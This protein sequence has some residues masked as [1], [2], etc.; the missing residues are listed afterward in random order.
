MIRNLPTS[1]VLTFPL[2]SCQKICFAD[3]IYNRGREFIKALHTG[4]DRRIHLLPK[5]RE[6]LCS[7]Y[8]SLQPKALSMH[9]SQ[10]TGWAGGWC[11]LFPVPTQ[12]IGHFKNLWL[13]F[14][15]SSFPTHVLHDSREYTFKNDASHNEAWTWIFW[16]HFPFGRCLADVW[17]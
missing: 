8:S 11:F 5:L 10:Q 17:L 9:W 13:L 15:F 7:Y 2:I 16:Y 4:F 6:P 12:I 1:W 3:V 14:S